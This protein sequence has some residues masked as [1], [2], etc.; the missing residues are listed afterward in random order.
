MLPVRAVATLLAALAGIDRRQA[1]AMNGAAVA[2]DRRFS[3]LLVRALCLLA[4]WVILMGPGLKDLP[5]GIAA[6]AAGVWAST[7][8]W[9][10]GGRLS[11]GGLIRFLLRF[12]PQS[13]VAGVDVAR[14]ASARDPDLRPGFATC[15]SIVPDGVARDS[16]CAVMSLQPGKLPVSVAADGMLLIHCLDL[17]EPI[18]EQVAADEIAFCRVLREERRDG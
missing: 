8:L 1:E 17:R 18:A 9:P 2:D 4:L 12:L 13:V 6:S 3:A 15:R 7:A 16:A 10:P 14:R 5:V 11:L